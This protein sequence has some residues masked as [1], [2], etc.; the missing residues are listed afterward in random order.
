LIRIKGKWPNTRPKTKIVNQ[1]SVYD[2]VLRQMYEE[3][4]E[5]EKSEIIPKVSPTPL[6]YKSY[7]IKVL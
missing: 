7:L 5:G 3:A 2:L 1:K 4:K 6:P